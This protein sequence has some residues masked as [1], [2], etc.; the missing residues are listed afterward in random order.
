MRNLE[1]ESIRSRVESM[2]GGV[3]TDVEDSHRNKME[4]C[5]L[6]HA[7]HSAAKSD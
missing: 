7:K 3:M 6:T 1:A 4:Q 5:C 2:G